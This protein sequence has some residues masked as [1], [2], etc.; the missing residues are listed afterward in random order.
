V[1]GF[2]NQQLA[3]MAALDGNKISARKTDAWIRAHGK[4]RLEQL[5]DDEC[6]ELRTDL[7]GRAD[8]DGR[9]TSG[10]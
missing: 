4:A 1:S 2:S 3:A 7:K 6:Q 5:T 9:Y 10:K 8:R